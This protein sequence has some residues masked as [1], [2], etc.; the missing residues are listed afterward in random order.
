[1]TKS[2]QNTSNPSDSAEEQFL[3]EISISKHISQQAN[4]LFKEKR[5]NPKDFLFEADPNVQDIDE[6]ADN[7]FEALYDHTNNK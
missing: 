7:L 1:M 5:K 3:Q 6:L 2:D 4:D